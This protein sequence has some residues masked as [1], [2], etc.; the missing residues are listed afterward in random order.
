[1]SILSNKIAKVIGLTSIVALLISSTV[2]KA[3]EELAPDQN[4]NY[5]RSME[6]YISEKD[7]LLK[8][9]GKTIQATYK[10]IDDM[11]LKQ[12]RKALRRSNRQERRLARINNRSYYYN[13][14]YY[15]F[16]ANP[17]NYG[18]NYGYNYNYNYGFNNG[19][20]PYHYSA[21]SCGLNTVA[22]AAILGLGLYWWLR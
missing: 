19:Y 9:Q 8:N 1:M 6:K 13:N 21:P 17:Y 5:R 12:E 7:E 2:T 15:S 10:A 4:P 14:P 11:Q 20:S 3:Q 18:Y 16:N 22:S